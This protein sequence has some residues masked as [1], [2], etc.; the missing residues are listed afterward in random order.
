MAGSLGTTAAR[1]TN[2]KSG[3]EWRVRQEPLPP[4]QRDHNWVV[5]GEFIKNH[6]YPANKPRTMVKGKFVK[7][8][9]HSSIN[10]KRVLKGKFAKEP[11]P[12]IIATF[13]LFYKIG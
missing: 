4:D 13:D 5:N 7:N 2:P 8:Y 1:P 9:W 11:Q 12:P 3:G 6:C 10:D